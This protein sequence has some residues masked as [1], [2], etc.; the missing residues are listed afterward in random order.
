MMD[1][2]QL[3][4]RIERIESH[5]AIQQL[6]SRYALAIDA[7]DID[8]WIGL[9]VEDV[10]CGKF[11]KG[12]EALRRFIDPSVRTFYR[13]HHQICGQ[14]V[15]FLDDDNATGKVYCRAEHE[16][17]GQWIVMIICYFDTYARRNGQWYFL[18]RREKHWYSTDILERPTG[19]NFQRWAEWADQKPELPHAFPS[20]QPFWSQSDPALLREL[21]TEP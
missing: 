21:S 6:P 5:Q 15:D 13:S 17:R 4:K 11:G 2:A 7:R 14:V 1:L 10:D 12:R 19:P 9:F 18:R 3:Q 16:V 20:W 8:T